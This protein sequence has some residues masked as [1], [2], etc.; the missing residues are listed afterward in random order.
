MEKNIKMLQLI[1]GDVVLGEVS[2]NGDEVTIKKPMQIMIDP[3]QGVGMVPYLVMYTNKEMSEAIFD[4]KHIVQI[5]DDFAEEFKNKY[6]EY[7]TGIKTEPKL[8]ILV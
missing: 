5:M 3:M 1:T 7:S 4:K 8:E 6:I 2:Y